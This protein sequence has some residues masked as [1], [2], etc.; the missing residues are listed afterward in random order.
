MM[1]LDVVQNSHALSAPQRYSGK[2]EEDSSVAA[3]LDHFE[4]VAPP[5]LANKVA[6]G[7]EE[8]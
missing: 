2:P 5:A 6:V 8:L 1:R 4:Q 7:Y 3:S